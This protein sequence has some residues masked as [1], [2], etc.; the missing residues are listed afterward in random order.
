MQPVGVGPNEVIDLATLNL[1]DAILYHTTYYVIPKNLCP[2]FL[3]YINDRTIPVDSCFCFLFKFLMF[4]IL[5][6]YSGYL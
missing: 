3:N 1:T 2:L 4:G 5:F 6:H